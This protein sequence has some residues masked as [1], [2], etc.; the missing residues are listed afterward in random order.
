MNAKTI[1]ETA[2]DVSLLSGD[3]IPLLL[4]AAVLVA[5][6]VIGLMVWKK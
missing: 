3:L 2:R 1:V 4:A 5:F 6:C